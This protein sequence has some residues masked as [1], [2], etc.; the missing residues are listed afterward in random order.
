VSSWR[1]IITITITTIITTATSVTT[2][3]TITG[4]GG[5]IITTTTTITKHFCLRSPASRQPAN[6]GRGS[7][8]GPSNE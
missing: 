5:A 4:G 7:R 6:S 8:V 3:I 2:T 1:N